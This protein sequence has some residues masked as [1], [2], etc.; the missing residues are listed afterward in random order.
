M[1]ERLDPEV[2]LVLAVFSLGLILGI[3]L[4][5]RKNRQIRRQAQRNAEMYELIRDLH[6]WTMETTMNCSVR[7]EGWFDEYLTRARFINIVNRA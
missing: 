4:R 2:E 1:S 5:E 6:V 3:H 7:D